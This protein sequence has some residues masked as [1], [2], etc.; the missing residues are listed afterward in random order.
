MADVD[1]KQLMLQVD[2]S[3]E[4]LRTNLVRGD[5]EVARFTSET[6]RRLDATDRRFS[7]LG[8]PLSTVAAGVQR[9]N[10]QIATIGATAARVQAQVAAASNGI[11]TT[12]LASTST[13]AAALSANQIADYSDSYTRFTNQLKVAG[14]EGGK[15]GTTQEQLYQI[16]QRY[17]V[18]LEA[19]GQL[20]GRTSQAAK[21]LGA[22]QSELMQFTSGIAAALKVQGGSAD[23]SRGA[24]IQLTQALGGEI[25]RA[26]EFNSM[27]E[28]ALPIL[29]AVANGVDRFGGS[30]T[31]LRAEVVAG[32]LKSAEFF[33]GFLRGSSDLEKQAEKATL[34]IGNSFTVL[35]N[36]LGKYIGEAGAASTA[37]EKVSAGI[38]G[39][40][41]NLD[42]I[43]PALAVIGAG[44]ATRA[45]V[46]G[47]AIA[48]TEVGLFVKAL[49]QE[50]VVMLGGKVAAAQKAQAVATA[51]QAE[52]SAIEATIAARRAD[53]EII[54]ANLALI[55]KQ[56]AEA[57]QAQA[58]VRANAAAGFGS[59]GVT[60]SFPDAARAQRDFES[61]IRLRERLRVANGEIAAS[62]LTLVGAQ[63]RAT[64]ATAA[65]TAATTAATLAARA[66][67]AA[68]K[69]FA[70]ALTL[71]GGSV[72]GG[73]AVLAIGAI[74]GAIML[75][76]DSVAEAKRR[77]EEFV[78]SGKDLSAFM[79][80]VASLS[81]S[82]A[83]QIGGVGATASGAVG[84]VNSLTAA[85]G[86]LATSLRDVAEEA[87]R[88][89][90]ETARAF[91]AKAEQD[92]A[93]YKSK[94]ESRQQSTSSVARF[95]YFEKSDED[96][97][98][99][100]FYLDRYNEAKSRQAAA[101]RTRHAIEREP[102]QSFTP[103]ANRTKQTDI[104][105]AD[106]GQTV[107][108]DLTIARQ[109]GNKAQIADLKAQKFE[110]DQ[111]SKYRKDGLSAEAASAQA[112]KD[113]AKFQ[114]ASGEK[115]AAAD[116][117][118]S[119]RGA[120]A[121]KRQE[122]AAVRDAAADARAYASASRQAD[123][124]IA[125]AR[126]QLTGS[127]EERANIEKARIEAERLNRDQEIASQGPNGSKRFTAAEVDVLQTKNRQRAELE[128]EV[129]DL[130]ERRRLAQE[131]LDATL[132]G[133][134][135][136]QDIATLQASLATTT[137]LR[138]DL[139]LRLLDIQR[140]EEEARLRAITV[141]NGATAAEERKAKERLAA[142]P[143]IYD[144]R[145]QQTERDNESPM[146]RRRRETADRAANLGDQLETIEVSFLDNMND[147]LAEGATR[148]LK[149]KGAAGDFFNQLIEDVIRLNIQQ[150]A[151]GS[152]GL[153]GGL[154]KLTGLA[155]GGNALAGS[156]STANSNVASLA[157]GIEARNLKGF[158]GGG[159]TGDIN[160]GKVAGVVHGQEFVFDAA[161]TARIGRSQLEA[162]RNGS[163]RTP[164]VSRT[165]LAGAMS[166]G[167]VR[168][169]I[170]EGAL[171]EPRIAAVSGNVAAQMVATAAPAMVGAASGDAQ[172][173]FAR[174]ARR[175]IS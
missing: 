115:E 109:S 25:V 83:A 12:L 54:A 79:K 61:Q 40:A 107:T 16:A 147:Q 1:V 70:G 152:G 41:N 94:F 34:T 175:Q 103:S 136:Q 47:I 10:A 114:A 132:D 84:G 111:Y 31:K 95:G 168:I 159:Y 2:A 50:R 43:G 74:V 126:A 151:G 29:Q 100:K 37:T 48:T 24:L 173:S 172:A 131:A 85:A 120:A 105:M 22:S 23:S 166:G 26:E 106:R 80:E 4:L 97:A 130:G 108:R 35:N 66:G 125:A 32:K 134:A 140:E 57:L 163:F 128:A 150:A 119:A 36:A 89:K 6:Q 38:Q 91:E 11:R 44:F 165:A 51:A 149:L 63:A 68:G 18:Q 117:A 170:A 8:R 62:E 145:R 160:P 3:V 69:L 58:A 137:G 75:Y 113:K 158:S 27:N 52:V 135:T 46:P 157:A 90:L 116:S 33:Q 21:E 148:F 93:Y 88:S 141:V 139:E 77:D 112:S 133:L 118:R 45:L 98:A 14:L 162:M 9:A 164:S 49:D 129:V 28:G 64:A 96:K 144:L 30:I 19:L 167:V 102:W 169:E 110:I 65:S 17:G 153:L 122:A 55:D 78:Q 20:Y 81:G 138:R 161:S 76:R 67:A 15:L 101:E 13:I 53:A 86:K 154:L 123:N 99:D 73:A 146:Q 127:A 174:R 155:T 59:V 121:A 171:F 142:L 143:Q 82:A 72:A 60:R 71:I 42:V 92:E 5:R 87:R 156:I 124:D 7:Q 39:L 56:R 104:D